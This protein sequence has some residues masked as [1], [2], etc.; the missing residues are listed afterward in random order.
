[1][2]LGVTTGA[3]DEGS[4]RH[5]GGDASPRCHRLQEEVRL[6]FHQVL[7]RGCG[8][9]QA[10]TPA[11]AEAEASGKATGLSP[12][13]LRA[14]TDAMFP[15]R[16]GGRGFKHSTAPAQPYRPGLCAGGR[17]RK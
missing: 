16:H 9:R 14:P 3:G 5:R 12:D 11:A 2:V 7:S 6:F 8:Q 1:M 10:A 4:Q 13:R 15:A 17:S